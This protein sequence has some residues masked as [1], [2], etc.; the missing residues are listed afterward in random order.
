MENSRIP[1]LKEVEDID[2]DPERDF[3]SATPEEIKKGYTTDI[4][5]VSA[6]EIL[7]HLNLEDTIVVAEIFPRGSGVMCG[8]PEVLNLLSSVPVEVWSLSEGE[9]FSSKEVI[10][11]IRGPYSAFGVFETPILGI[12]AHSSGWAT[13]ARECKVA[14]GEKIVLSFGARHVHPAVAPVMER[15]AIVGGADGAA[16]IL[17]AKLAG[18][19]PGGTIP[20]AAILIVG[21]TVIAAQVFQEVIPPHYSRIILV[22]TFKDEAEESLRVARA[23]G[24]NLEG[25]RLDTPEERGGVTPGLVEEV[26][27]RL[28][29]AGF[30]QVK[31]VV[32]GGLNPVRIQALKDKVD[33]F[34]VG[35]YISGH[36]PVDMTM[37]L[38]EIGGDKIAKRGRL[39]G[40]IPNP[41]LKQIK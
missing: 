16:C 15:S 33:I 27:V 26:R 40:V 2:I 11:R 38:K 30:S 36:P 6:Q 22:D 9:E 1:T 17:G 24:R 13:A 4:Y 14:A 31:I 35:S 34:G 28:D 37:D 8:V 39:P 41:R 5:F 25:V 7:R 19:E 10:M 29:Q 3:Y 18:K 12:L 21:D 20:H 23:L 32:S